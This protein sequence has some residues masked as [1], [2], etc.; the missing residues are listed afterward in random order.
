MFNSPELQNATQTSSSIT[1]IILPE[2]KKDEIKNLL[3]E[4]LIRKDSNLLKPYDLG[5]LSKSVSISA[6]DTI[7]DILLC[8]REY[9]INKYI[10]DNIKNL[11]IRKIFDSM[12]I[13]LE[14]LMINGIDV[15]TEEF[16]A[17]IIGFLNKNCL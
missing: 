13:S 14:C 7:K 16:Y 2:I 11:T 9:Y 6:N 15:N 3:K 5:H 1:E 4:F 12:I 10:D 8:L 17:L